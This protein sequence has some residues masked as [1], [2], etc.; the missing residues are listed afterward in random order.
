MWERPCGWLTI[1]PPQDDTTVQFI[2]PP[3]SLLT[4]ACRTDILLTKACQRPPLGGMQKPIVSGQVS[5][6]TVK[7]G[8]EIVSQVTKPRTWI[9]RMQ[10]YHFEAPFTTCRCFNLIAMGRLHAMIILHACDLCPGFCG[11]AHGLHTVVCGPLR[12]LSPSE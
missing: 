11:Q 9:A 7:D 10:N 4:C 8:T 6:G 2:S 3:T 12:H 1:L 5:K